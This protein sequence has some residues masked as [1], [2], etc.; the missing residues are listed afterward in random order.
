ME[1][2]LDKLTLK[3]FFDIASKRRYETRS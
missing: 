2:N 1:N 3:E